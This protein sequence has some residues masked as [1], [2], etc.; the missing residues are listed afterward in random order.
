MV[1]VFLHRHQNFILYFIIHI[2]FYIHLLSAWPKPKISE[3]FLAASYTNHSKTSFQLSLIW[4][5]Y[6]PTWMHA[7]QLIHNSTLKK[8]IYCDY[9]W[10]ILSRLTLIL[11]FLFYRNENS[12]GMITS[13]QTKNIEKNRFI[14]HV[15]ISDVRFLTLIRLEMNLITNSGTYVLHKVVGR[16]DS[17]TLF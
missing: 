10:Y 1:L 14:H 12:A 6:K 11:I 9:H 17:L 15:F 4:P 7:L 16:L 5:L 3:S 2:S 13:R 8:F